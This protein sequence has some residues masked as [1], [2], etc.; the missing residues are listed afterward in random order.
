[1]ANITKINMLDSAD[2]IMPR[3]TKEVE[4]K[5]IVLV[6]TSEFYPV[7]IYQCKIS[8][9]RVAQACG[10]FSDAVVT[11]GLLSYVKEMTVDEC[12]EMHKSLSFKLFSEHKIT[13]LKPNG[14]L[15]VSKTLAGRSTSNGACDG[16][17]YSD[18]GGNFNNVLVVASVTISLFDSYQQVD[19]EKSLLKLPSGYNCHINDA[20]CMD[21]ENGFTFWDDNTDKSCVVRSYDLLFDGKANKSVILSEGVTNTL[22]TSNGDVPF[23]I[24]VKGH[25]EVCGH[26][27]Y[28]TEHPRLKIL[29]SNG[30]KFGF[31][32]SISAF[33]V[34]MFTYMNSKFVHLERH[35]QNQI[36]NLH[37]SLVMKQ[38]E[39][40]KETLNTQLALAYSSPT[41][42]AYLRMRKPGF[43]ALP[44]GEV[45]YLVKCQAVPVIRS[46]LKEC[47][48]EFPVVY[49]NQTWFMTPRTHIL[50]R[51]GNEIPCSEI[52]PVHYQIDGLW[53]SFSP[54]AQKAVEPDEIRPSQKSEWTYLSSGSLST[55]GIY[56]T[57]ALD[58]FRKQIL[59]P[60]D[61]KTVL[62]TLANIAADVSYHD[63]GFN[64]GKLID[65]NKMDSAIT[66][67]L[68]KIVGFFGWFGSSV[69]IIIGLYVTLRITKF[70]FDTCVHGLALYQAYGFDYRMSAMFWDALTTHFLTRPRTVVTSKGTSTCKLDDEIV[71]LNSILTVPTA[72]SFTQHKGSCHNKSFIH[73]RVAF[74]NTTNQDESYICVDNKEEVAKTE[75]GVSILGATNLDSTMILHIKKCICGNPRYIVHR[76]K[77]SDSSTD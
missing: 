51:K 27:A 5:Q 3:S 26:S 44:A 74:L 15:T 28:Q 61:K 35:I 47:F 72:P 9:I 24:M 21:I 32:K 42:F 37:A 55:S 69:S 41:D 45:M 31:K 56:D 10:T 70:L 52:L 54:K 2:C 49:N 38:C 66:T 23:S 59:F 30:I 17:S 71:P 34:D 20:H 12:R 57:A 14:T 19:S 58:S 62:T 6:Q 36:T 65:D 8:I 60:Y 16:S 75:S 29:I 40:D 43:T 18:A 50:Q 63:Q 39:S 7:H 73:F 11:G 25:T 33:N 13:G 68:G 53:Y 22:F 48:T 1:M 46:H 77:T 76:T 4:E 64:F 67:Y